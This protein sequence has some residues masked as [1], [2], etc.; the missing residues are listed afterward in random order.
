MICLNSDSE[1]SQFVAKSGHVV[2][3]RTTS[4]I[5]GRAR[6]RPILPAPSI[7]GQELRQSITIL[8]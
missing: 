3:W 1:D 5:T 2:R 8:N 4:L 7:A 6:K